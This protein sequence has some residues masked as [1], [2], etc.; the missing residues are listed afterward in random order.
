METSMIEKLDAARSSF[1]V[2]AT[3]G[4]AIYFGTYIV[5]DLIQFTEIPGLLRWIRLFAW[6][7]FLISTI[8]L[9]KL[10]RELKS[11]YKMKDAVFGELYQHNRLKSFKIGYFVVIGITSIFYLLYSYFVISVK[12]A[13]DITLYLGVLSFLVSNMFYNRD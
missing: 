8:R 10:K 13:T 1:W 7:T 2:W 4:W 5:T 11:D 9:V 12:L 3:I 6:L